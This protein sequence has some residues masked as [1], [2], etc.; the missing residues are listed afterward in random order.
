MT[1]AVNRMPTG[2]PRRRDVGF[3]YLGLIIL[4]AMLGLVASA[5]LKMGVLLQ[6]NAA[7]QELLYIGAQFSDALASYAAATPP[8]QPRQPPSLKELLKDPRFP[9]ARRHL[10][11]LFVDPVTGKAT[12]GIMYLAG[13]TGVTGVYSLSQAKP[14][15]V[16][17]F[18][19]RFQ[20]F[21]RKTHL[22]DWKFTQAQAVLARLPVASAPLSNASA[23]ATLP[24]LK[25]AVQ[26]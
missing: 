11:K 2:K 15:K 13:E 10:R 7:E 17:N 14:I 24:P 19:T 26:E 5:T 4:V 21:E 12:W 16:A 8:G 20:S 22:S 1:A 6:R 18:D 23:E 3:T 25:G 9:N